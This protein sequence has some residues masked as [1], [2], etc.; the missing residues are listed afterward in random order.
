MT[1]T[2]TTPKDFFLRLGA[3]IA[4][5]VSVIALVN[6]AFSIINYA[7][8]DQLAGYFYANTVAWPISLLI[9]FVPILYVLEWLIAKDITAQPEKKDI[10]IRRWSI[11]L[12]LFLTGLA[13]AI[14][15]V[16]LINVYLNGEIS[17]RFGWKVF[18]V[19]VIATA[20]FKFYFFSLNEN[21][22]RAQ[23]AKKFNA[24][25]GI[26][27]VLA[28]IVS[29]FLV[30]GSPTKQRNIRFDNQ[31]VNDLQNIQ[32]QVV[33][34]WQQKEKMPATLADLKDSISGYQIPKD[35]E[36]KA[37][38]EYS[39]KGPMSFEL[40]ANFALKAEDLS[41]RG[42]YYGR[43]GGMIGYDTAIPYPAPG[44]VNEDWK[45]E[46]GRT[47]FTRT[48]DPQIYPPYKPGSTRAI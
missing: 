19:L 23:L 5:Y 14:D 31:R 24:W 10:W 40:C 26:V 48:I 38:Y 32:W 13:I 41:G 25:A 9:I 4:L 39:V 17:A 34:Q 27:L 16:T 2:K 18:V 12:T 15:L 1:P 6:L 45:H 7:F 21:F 11:F 29:G 42:G 36:T 3:I 8:P 43:G 33:N 47:C 37:S 46:A 35:P 22:K 20:V 30:V 28:A 44:G